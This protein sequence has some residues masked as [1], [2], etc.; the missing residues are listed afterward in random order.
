MK[1]LLFAICLLLVSALGRAQNPGTFTHADT[2]RGSNTPQRAW[3]DV[4]YYDLHVAFNPADSS[5]R[6]YNRI[7]YRVLRPRN[8]MQIDLMVPLRVDSMVQNGSSLV[9][10]RD[11]NAYLVRLKALQPLGS[12]QN[13]TVYYQGRPQ[14]ARMPPWDGG[15]TWTRD[16]LGNPWIATSCQGI[17]ASVWW[18]NK[19]Y[20]GDEPDSQQISIRVPDTLMDISNGRSR[21][22]IEHPDG[23][24]TFTWFVKDP[25][26]NY[27]VAA[28]IGKY[29]HFT[30]SYQGLDGPLSLDFWPLPYHLAQAR[31]QFRQ[32][33]PMLK[34]F[35]YWFG[36]YP[37]YRDGY[38][39]VEDPYLGMEHQSCIAYGN[40]Y[41]DGYL[42]RDLSGTGLGLSWDYIIIH[43]SAHE[44][45]GNSITTR[46]LADM[47]VH[48]GF[49]DYAE[50]LYVESLYGKKA[51]ERYVIGCRKNIRNDRP[52]IAAYGV[53][54]EGSEDMYY[55]GSNLL[56]MIRNIL[57]NDQ[58]W[59]N[60]LRGLNKKF[61]HQIVS[62]RMVENYIS[63][64]CRMN[65]G[66]V[67][68]EYL[69]T[70]QIPVLEYHLSPDS[71]KFRWT[72][73]VPGFRMPVRVQLKGS[74]YHLIYPNSSWKTL[75][76]QVDPQDFSIDPNFY[77]RARKV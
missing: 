68:N 60:I 18:P 31:V 19:D 54:Q 7:S 34:C 33:K 30:D 51:G 9:Y 11:G 37:W 12:I 32:V 55:K 38:K 39:L 2:L 43:E 49:A 63:Q 14:V 24:R 46:D 20:Q 5:I 15:V 42:G 35:E 72:K 66:P 40:H 4:T 26:N 48:E 25:I 29:A 8:L 59:R 16:S 3:W 71:L 70:T 6:G 77:I 65:L 67:F 73:V 52:I 58:E 36:P 28:N 41:R 56:N 53:N 44:W 45:F 1:R 74:G 10:S 50:S 13:L 64:R 21:G 75:K 57:D 17:G 62:S 61:W 47:W 27:D 23:T 22:M 69:R 76:V